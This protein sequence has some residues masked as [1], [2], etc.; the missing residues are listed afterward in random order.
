MTS[1]SCLF[2]LNQSSLGACQPD[3]NWSGQCLGINAQNACPINFGLN[4][5]QIEQLHILARPLKERTSACS[6]AD[7]ILRCLILVAPAA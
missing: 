4:F 3:V 2:A 6:T 7:P 5:V 1:L